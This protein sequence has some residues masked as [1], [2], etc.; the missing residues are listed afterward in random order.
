[1]TFQAIC[2]FSFYLSMLVLGLSPASADLGMSYTISGDY[3]PTTSI[4]QLAG[5]SDTFS[6][7]FV[8]LVQLIVGRFPSFEHAFAFLTGAESSGS[9]HMQRVAADNP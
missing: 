2:V 8:L 9:R 5:P 1:M 4:S 6:M 7:S 3:S